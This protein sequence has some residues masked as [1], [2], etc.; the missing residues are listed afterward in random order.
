MCH[1]YMYLRNKP[2]AEARG[3]APLYVGASLLGHVCF[4][5]FPFAEQTNRPWD[6]AQG[7]YSQSQIPQDV[8]KRGV[9]RFH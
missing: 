9:E 7:V 2:L 3:R 8:E 1:T 6:V 4:S 5:V